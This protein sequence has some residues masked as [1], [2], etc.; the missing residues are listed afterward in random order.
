MEQK[1]LAP[2]LRSIFLTSFPSF[3]LAEFFF[4]FLYYIVINGIQWVYFLVA[5][6]TTAEVEAN[7]EIF[8][9]V[10]ISLFLLGVVAVSIITCLEL[11]TI[12]LITVYDANRDD[13][14]PLRTLI[15]FAWERIRLIMT[16]RTFPL[17]LIVMFFPKEHIGP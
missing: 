15:R 7:I 8:G 14:I 3:L 10:N 6:W 17:F 12:I 13:H 2:F 9:P 11:A 4:A 16:I 5:S 1:R